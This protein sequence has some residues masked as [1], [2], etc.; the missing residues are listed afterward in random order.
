[1]KGQPKELV[2][3][4][5]GNNVSAE[6]KDVKVVRVHKAGEKDGQREGMRLLIE[7]VLKGM[8]DYPESIIVTYFMGE[9]TTVFKVD[10]DQKCLGQIIGAKGKNISGVRAIVAAT[11]A[12]QGIRA[13]VEIPFYAPQGG[14]RDD[15]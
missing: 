15:D 3:S 10:C 4:R 8:V 11:M 5:T 13:I 6:E 2:S 1:M 14:H 9:K 12:R 7:T